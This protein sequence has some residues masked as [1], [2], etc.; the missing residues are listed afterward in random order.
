V[1]LHG[2]EVQRVDAPGLN[3]LSNNVIVMK[4]MMRR[5]LMLKPNVLIAKQLAEIGFDAT[6]KV[7]AVMIIM[8]TMILLLE[9]SLP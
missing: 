8:V 6:V 7:W 4:M 3:M 9:P 5:I 2:R 1:N